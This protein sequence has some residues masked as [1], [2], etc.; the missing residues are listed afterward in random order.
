MNI[1][2]FTNGINGL[3]TMIAHELEDRHTVRHD[4]CLC[5]FTKWID[6]MYKD[7]EIPEAFL[8][9]PHDSNKNGCYDN[10]AEFVRR[11][12]QSHF[13]ILAY[14][15]SDRSEPRIPAIGESPNLTYITER[16]AN[17][18]LPKVFGL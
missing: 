4:D 18:V 6:E 8:L 2:V 5:K 14:H 7:E 15:D 13:Y 12:P 9:H 17:E 16:T 3:S 10:I 11:C 1:G